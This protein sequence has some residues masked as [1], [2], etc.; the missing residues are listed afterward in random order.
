[1]RA[2]RFRRRLVSAALA[3]YV[4]FV[5]LITLTPQMPGTGLV[6]RIVDRF[7]YELELRGITSIQFLDIEFFGNILMFVPLGV[8]SALLIPRKAWWT[9]LLLGT[10]FS[11]LIELSQAAFLPSRYPEVRDL[12]SN[13]TGFLIG[14]AASVTLR[15]IVSHRDSLVELDRRAAE[16]RR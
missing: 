12:V 15:L 6:G 14:A 8:F 13:T 9:L 1:M 5:L 4:V 3:I 11:G 10:A 2:S 7:L 16:Q